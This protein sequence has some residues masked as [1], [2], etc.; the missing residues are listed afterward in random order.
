MTKT[1]AVINY[2]GGTCKTST[3]SSLASALQLKGYIVLTI[4]MDGQANLSLS[5]GINDDENNTYN[6]LRGKCS[7]RPIEIKE[8]LWVIPSTIDLNAL[9]TEMALEPGKEYTLKEKL[10]PIKNQYDFIL[11]DC[12]PSIGLTTLNAL[13]AADMYLIPITP[14]HY[15]LKGLTS[16]LSVANKV[17][18]RLNNK[19]ELEGVLVARYSKRTVFHRQVYDALVKKFGGKVYKTTIRENIALV[20]A[21]SMKQSIFEYAPKSNGAYD[22]SLFCDEFL[23]KN[24]PYVP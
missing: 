11:L 8:N 9:D 21:S 16:L 15:S 3:V 5:F 20:E 23:S 22:Y 24:L 1:I 18:A 17:K 4:D 12:A 19:L 7:L 6:L 13:T 10:E 14:G 2:K